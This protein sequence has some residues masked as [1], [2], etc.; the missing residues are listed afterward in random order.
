[1]CNDDILHQQTDVAIRTKNH[2][3]MCIPG[4]FGLVPRQSEKVNNQHATEV[5]SLYF[6]AAG[7]S[8]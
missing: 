2:Y 3:I 4:K 8:E 6:T 5:V 7:C 1:M